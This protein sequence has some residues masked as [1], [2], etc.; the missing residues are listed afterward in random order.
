MRSK[1]CARSLASS[2]A[3]A[4]RSASSSSLRGEEPIEIGGGRRAEQRR[5]ARPASREPSTR[6]PRLWRSRQAALRIALVADRQ[7]DE[8]VQVRRSALC[9]SSQLLRPPGRSA[10][11]GATACFLSP[12]SVKSRPNDSASRSSASLLRWPAPVTPPIRPAPTRRGG[13]AA[14]RVGAP[15]IRST[16]SETGTPTRGRSASA[17]RTLDSLP[18]QSA[19]LVS[20]EARLSARAGCGFQSI[21]ETSCTIRGVSPPELRPGRSVVAART[22]AVE[23]LL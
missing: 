12:S 15:V 14:L 7:R 3:C 13:R 21:R 9:R 10:S 22:P 19:F 1:F 20:E 23:G 6:R 11:T 8:R 4:A 18:R 17:G 16:R 5:V 2:V